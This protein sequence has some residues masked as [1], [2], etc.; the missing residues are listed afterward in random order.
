[1]Q[2]KG[3]YQHEMLS[4]ALLTQLSGVCLSGNCGT[5]EA[6][7]ES[8]HTSLCPASE[9]SSRLWMPTS[10]SDSAVGT[11]PRSGNASE[12]DWRTKSSKSTNCRGAPPLARPPAPHEIGPLPS[13][14]EQS[15]PSCLEALPP[16]TPSSASTTQGSSTAGGTMEATSPLG[17]RSGSRHRPGTL[18]AGRPRAL[19]RFAR[20]RQ[21]AALESSG[22]AGACATHQ[23]RPAGTGGGRGEA[24]APPPGPP[25][26]RP[27]QEAGRQLARS[28][29]REQE[30]LGPGL[31][32]KAREHLLFAGVERGED[33]LAT[34]TLPG[35]RGPAA[36]GVRRAL[37]AAETAAHDN[38]A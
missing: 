28:R 11:G 24:A 13:V 15:L 23:T 5:S 29:E 1:M 20:T 21:R 9:L 16:S 8:T 3:L 33:P 34:A 26:L 18:P 2:P 19:P 38:K 12:L 31:E 6:C 7:A 14:P 22:A 35:L 10:S 17:S 4:K 25:R 36:G 30:A 37:G 32:Q 27:P